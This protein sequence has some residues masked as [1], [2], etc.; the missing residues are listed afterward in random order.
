MDLKLKEIEG[1]A[2]KAGGNAVEELIVQ[3][4]TAKPKLHVNVHKR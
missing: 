2:G 1:F 4:A 3:V